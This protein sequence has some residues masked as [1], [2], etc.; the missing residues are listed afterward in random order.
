MDTDTPLDSD[1]F[2]APKPKKRKTTGQSAP[3]NINPYSKYTIIAWVPHVGAALAVPDLISD[4]R[5][6][7]G[8]HF[9]VFSMND[10]EEEEWQEHGGIL[11]VDLSSIENDTNKL[12]CQLFEKADYV[13]YVHE[14]SDR[15]A[16][17][18]ALLEVSTRTN[19]E[20]YVHVGNAMTPEH[21]MHQHLDYAVAVTYCWK[22]V[23]NT[24]HQAFP[25]HFYSVS[26]SWAEHQ[27]PWPFTIAT[28]LGP[29]AEGGHVHIGAKEWR[30]QVQRAMT[31]VITVNAKWLA[32]Y[33]HKMPQH[34]K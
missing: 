29:E 18:I 21:N 23:L 31:G 20:D 25:G 32:Q 27:Y 24:W 15:R 12:V 5:S 33:I 34:A 4:I 2:D 10:M 3:V 16:C 14:A 9:P 30:Q 7:M 19:I 8:E 17:E 1:L 6:A 22:E 13:Y 11:T 28:S 26:S